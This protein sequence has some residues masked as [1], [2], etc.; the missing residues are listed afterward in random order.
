[1]S[2]HD[3]IHGD[4][5]ENCVL[6]GR[7]FLR[8]YTGDICEV[9]LKEEER[10]EKLG[11]IVKSIKPRKARFDYKCDNCGAAIPKGT[12]YWRFDLVRKYLHAE[13]DGCMFSLLRKE[14]FP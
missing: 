8:G 9:C 3:H 6:C 7:M 14:G 4:A 1:V 5:R 11:Q 13:I 12:K 2:E 10:I